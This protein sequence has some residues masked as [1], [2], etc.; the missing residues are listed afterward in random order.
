M[1]LIFG[2]F[3]NTDIINQTITVQIEVRK[4]CLRVVELLLEDLE[5]LHF[6]KQCCHCFQIKVVRYL[7]IGST[8]RYCLI[9]PKQ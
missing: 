9:S 6:T 7:L 1:Y 5:I 8:D 4:V 2:R 3:N